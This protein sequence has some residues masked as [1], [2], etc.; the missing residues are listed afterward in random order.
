MKN[1]ISNNYFHPLTGLEKYLLNFSILKI[2]KWQFY[3]TRCYKHF[4][5][6]PTVKLKYNTIYNIFTEI[7]LPSRHTGSPCVNT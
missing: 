7:F 2:A 6:P 5:I 4:K 1:V 3:G